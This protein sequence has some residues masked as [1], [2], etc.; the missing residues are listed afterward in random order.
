M[1][2]PDHIETLFYVACDGVRIDTFDN[3]SESLDAARRLAAEYT[4]LPGCEYSI[5]EVTTVET[6]HEIEP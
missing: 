5:L 6:I 4:K 2:D 1:K 3:C